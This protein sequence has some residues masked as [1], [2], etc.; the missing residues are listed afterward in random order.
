MR[1]RV[2]DQLEL[3]AREPWG[4]LSPR[5]LT[6]GYL[7]RTIGGTGRAHLNAAAPCICSDWKEDPQLWLFPDEGL[8]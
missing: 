3:F 7:Y 1:N 4:G 6:R 2:S 5:L 8:D